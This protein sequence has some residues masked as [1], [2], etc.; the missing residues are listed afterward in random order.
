MDLTSRCTLSVFV[1]A[2]DEMAEGRAGG[3]EVAD[4][5]CSDRPSL[6]QQAARSSAV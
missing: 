3:W 5:R 1:A 4:R 2:C 6:V